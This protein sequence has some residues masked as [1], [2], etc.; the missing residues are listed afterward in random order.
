MIHSLTVTEKLHCIARSML[1]ANSVIAFSSAPD[2]AIL[3]LAK[4]L[5]R[6]GLRQGLLEAL[7]HRSL[8]VARVCSVQEY[9]WM[10]AN[11]T[12]CDSSDE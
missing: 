7:S 11:V 2:I 12:L 1:T 5:L 3:I 9:I 4:Q 8:P 6:E 10:E